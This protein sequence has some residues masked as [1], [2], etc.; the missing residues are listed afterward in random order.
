M[1]C[2][3]VLAAGTSSR[4]GRPKQLLALGETTLLRAVVDTTLA[5]DLDEVV[6]VLGHASDEIAATLPPDP[7][8]RIVRNHRFGE[9]QSTSLRAG[10]L[11]MAQGTDAAVVLLGDQPGVTPAAIS[12]VIGE[13][14]RTRAPVVQASYGNRPGHP[15][16]LAAEVWP[17]AMRVTGDEGARAVIDAHRAERRLIEVGGDPPL[18]VDTEADYRRVRR[19]FEG[20]D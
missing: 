20:H 12:V 18:D 9:G 8:L 15:T 1:I 13:F 5:S 3:L 16:L 14:H 19:A 4:L 11:A 2:G 6:V 7:R 10:L 17:E